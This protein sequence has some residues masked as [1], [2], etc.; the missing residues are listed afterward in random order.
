MNGKNQLNIIKK[1][2][3]RKLEGTRKQMR[4]KGKEARKEIMIM[5]YAVILPRVER[6]M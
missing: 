3:R 4:D 5:R 2:R 1:E 6:K